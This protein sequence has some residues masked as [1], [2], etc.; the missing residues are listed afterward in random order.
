M[1]HIK[2]EGAFR[3]VRIS[4]HVYWVGAI[5]WGLRDFH[6]YLTSEGSTYNAYL[7][8]ADRITLVDTVKAAF[9]DEMMARIAAVIDPGEID[10]LISNHSEM[11]HTGAMPAVIAEIKPQ[12]IIASVNGVKALNE[13]FHWD[14]PVRAVA[15]GERLD[16]GG[17]AVRFY[18]TPMLHWPDSMFT[19]LEG[20]GVLFSNDAFGMHLASTERFVDELAPDCIW[21]EAGKYYANILLPYSPLIEKLIAKLPALDLDVQMIAPDHGPVWRRDPLE[22][23]KRYAHWAKQSYARKAVVV[24]DTMWESTARMAAAIGEGLSAGDLNVVMMPLAGSHRSAVISELLEAGAFL[25]GSPTFNGLILPSVADVLTY[26]KGLKPQHLVGAS[27]GSFGWGGQSVRLLAQ[28]LEAMNVV[29][30]D[31]G[32]GVRYVPDEVALLRCRALGESV[33]AQLNEKLA[34]T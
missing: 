8:L 5:D 14:V 25:V 6:G 11:D 20:D 18:E 31:E 4:E 19:Y 2:A 9:R 30:A 1:S 34:A 23:V 33:A 27:F 10:C 26:V 28:E 22:I 7:I 21:R 32:V 12:E 17:L 13:H 15:D 24:Y 29:L 3:A 16:L